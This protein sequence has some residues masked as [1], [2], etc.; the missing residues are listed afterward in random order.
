M[1]EDWEVPEV[2][3]L[4][5]GQR[6]AAV[7]DRTPLATYH[8]P[9]TLY[10]YDL[11]PDANAPAHTELVTGTYPGFWAARPVPQLPTLVLNP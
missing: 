11:A 3:A 6:A 7:L 9:G 2:R 8:D 1:I 5:A 4:F 10:L